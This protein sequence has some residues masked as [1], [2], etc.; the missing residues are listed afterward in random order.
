V[1]HE[2]VWERE[3]GRWRSA[4]WRAQPGLGAGARLDAVITTAAWRAAKRLVRARRIARRLASGGYT[5][6]LSI[7]EARA[8]RSQRAD[9]G[10]SRS[11]AR[12]AAQG[13]GTGRDGSAVVLSKK[14]AAIF[15][16]GEDE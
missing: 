5:T 13:P 14:V 16:K 8:A 2:L 10:A 9:R 1:W 15:H 11:R 12:P 6:A 4:H 3:L 7:Q